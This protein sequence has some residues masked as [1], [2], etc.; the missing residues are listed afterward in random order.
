MDNEARKCSEC[1]S[2]DIEDIAIDCEDGLSNCCGAPIDNQ[3]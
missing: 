3:E 1:Q 2:E